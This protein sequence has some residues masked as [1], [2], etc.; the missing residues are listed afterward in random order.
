MHMI[1]NLIFNNFNI[2]KLLKL[3]KIEV[4]LRSHLI[5]IPAVTGIKIENSKYLVYNNK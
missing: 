5:F 1:N 3:L 4:A 2:S